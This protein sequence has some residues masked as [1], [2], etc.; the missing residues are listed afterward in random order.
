[1]QH[2]EQEL[3]DLKQ[4]LL[5]MA[6]KSKAAVRKAISAVIDR[7]DTPAEEVKREDDVLDRLEV[8]IDERA[9][10]LL[11]K[12]P[13]ATQLRLITVAMKVNQNLERI[14]DEATTIA[15]RALELNKEPQL[16]PY[17]DLPRL[18]HLTLDM[19]DDALTAFINGD[20]T[21]AGE[22]VRRDKEADELNRQLHRELSSFMVEDP[23]TITR[24]L[25]LMVVSKSLER[26]ADHASN[27]AEE[28][29]FLYQA[30]DVRHSE[31]SPPEAPH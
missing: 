5:S 24:C 1:M 4:E 28:V 17:V 25:N 14:G 18:A 2:L 29:I 27:I 12:A 19:I 6:A 30:R 16:K 23:K 13:L 31:V 15:R 9:L 21:R 3:A 8:D 7:N 10:L 26:I 11:S 20:M 22:V